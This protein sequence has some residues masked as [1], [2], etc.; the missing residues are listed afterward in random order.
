MRETSGDTGEISSIIPSHSSGDDFDA[1]SSESHEFN[2]LKL[3]SSSN[4]QSTTIQNSPS[5]VLLSIPIDDD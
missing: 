3:V 1:A 4:G 5:N 2:S